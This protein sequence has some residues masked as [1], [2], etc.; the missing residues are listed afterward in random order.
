MFSTSIGSPVLQRSALR[1][2]NSTALRLNRLLASCICAP[3]R[4]AV[5][6]AVHLALPIPPQHQ[7]L[8]EQC[9]RPGA[10][11][12][13]LLYGYRVPAAHTDICAVPDLIP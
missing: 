5:L 7:R 10:L 8:A 9:H 3:V 13:V 11:P 2:P 6:E 1:F 12:E 4:A